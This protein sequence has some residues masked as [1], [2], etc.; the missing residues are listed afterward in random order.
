MNIAIGS[1][2][3]CENC[4]TLI[5]SKYGSGRFCNSQCARGFSTKH[6]RLEINKQ[7]SLTMKGKRVWSDEQVVARRAWANKWANIQKEQKLNRLVKIRGD[8]LNITY[9]ELQLYKESHKLCD[10]CGAGPETKRNAMNKN[11]VVDHCHRTK[12]FRGLLCVSCNRF[13]GYYENSKHLAEKYLDTE[14]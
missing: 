5:I 14:H 9:R 12:K 4:S 6:K 2:K 7:V 10:M 1:N 3:K 13:L 11:L 8:V